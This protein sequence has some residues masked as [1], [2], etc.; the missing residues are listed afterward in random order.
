MLLS[1]SVSVRTR[2]TLVP[3]LFLLLQ[4]TF[5]AQE[6]ASIEPPPPLAFSQAGVR[7][8]A[9]RITV[10]AV[11]LNAPLDLDG[12]LTEPLY[13]T[14]EPISDFVQN[15]PQF[16]V[17]ATERTEIWLSFDEENIYVSVRAWESQPD[18]MIANEMRRDSFNIMQNE[19]IGFFLDTFNDQRSGLLFQFNSLGGRMDGQ[20]QGPGNYNGDWNP[21]WEVAVGQFEGGWTAEVAVPFKSLTYRPGRSQIWGFNARRINRWKSEFTYLSNPPPGYGRRGI[22]YP[23]FAATLVGLEAPPSSRTLDIKPY[24]ISNV[25]SDV[26]SNISN[27][28]DGNIGLDVRYAITQNLSAD[29]TYNTDFAQVE[30]DEQQVNLTRFSL[31]FPEKREFFLENAGLFRFGATGFTNRGSSSAPTLFHSRRIGLESGRQ[32]PILAGGQMTG[33]VGD[34]SVG[35]INMQTKADTEQNVPATNFAVAR[36]QR[37]I[38]RRSSIGGIVTTRSDTLG[39]RGSA[40]AYGIDAAFGFYEN[41]EFQAYFAK[42]QNPGVSGGDTS[43]RARM[44]YDSDLWGVTVDQIGIG[45]NFNPAVGFVRRSDI[46]RTF[47]QSNYT[48]RPMGIDLIRQ[49]TFQGQ[50]EY[51]EN[52]VGQVE[53]REYQGQFQIQFENSDQFQVQYTDGY[54]LLPLNFKIADGV[55]IPAGGYTTDTVRVSF[56]LGTQ[57]ATSGTLSIQHSQFYDGHR[58]SYGYSRGRVNLHPQLALQPSISVNQIT[59]PFGDFTTQLYSSR[60]TYTVTPLMFVSGLVQYNSARNSMSTNVRLRWEYRPGSELFV[61][62]NEGRDTNVSGFSD[63]QNRSFIVKVNRLFRF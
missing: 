42:T 20:I 46:Q 30:A 19:S 60:I 47:V 38:L 1:F 2:V 9:N 39:G 45:A 53:T 36:V 34:Y 54:E 27:D 41:L 59:T 32:I 62:Y 33:R 22:S 49:F 40:S 12:R 3:L 26:L 58:W 55:R 31:Y 5:H 56:T 10:R 23:A 25:T 61:V 43:Y 14:E 24:V 11:R 18:R 29:F 48:P 4:G 50:I 21:L 6:R 52:T 13:D 63:L 15:E 8:E 51:V 28:I 57:R 17:D 37:D 16:D 7:D 44:E 35:V